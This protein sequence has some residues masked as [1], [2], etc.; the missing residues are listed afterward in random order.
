MN[1]EDEEEEEEMELSLLLLLL[2]YALEKKK[3]SFRKMLTRQQRRNRKGVFRREAL[4]TPEVAPFWQIYNSGQMLALITRCGFN[5]PF[6]NELLLLFTPYF[7]SCTPYGDGSCIVKKQRPKGGR[8]R[9]VSA[10]SCLALV[11]AWTR[12]RGSNMILQIV[13]GLT[14]SPL[15]LWLR[16]GRR[17]CVKVLNNNDL[18]AVKM[19]TDAKLEEFSV[20]V[21]E[22]Y[23]LLKKTWGATDGLKIRLQSPTDEIKQS[24]FYNGWT[25][26]HYTTNL[27]LFSPDGKIRAMY[28]NAPGCLHDS[29]LANWSGIYDKIEK[30][31]SKQGYS[32]VVDSA[33]NK[34]DRGGLIKSHQT[35][36][37]SDGARRQPFAL[38]DQA[39]S[40]RQLS[41]WGM[42]GLQASFPRLK[43]RLTYEEV[44]ERKIIMALIVLLYNFRA[45]TVGQNQIASTFMPWLERDANQYSR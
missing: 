6:F 24:L 43:D 31:H 18:A 45:S 8:K 13:F 14:S 26:D 39:T 1:V 28:V 5:H 36:V 44:G 2:R 21:E 22:K 25:H 12:T 3:R 16:F 42:R 7:D 30:L 11:L 40:L 23:P 29:T 15:D 32:V 19:P 27:F 10:V 34:E 20:I 37:G 35:N 4:Q 33:F 38:N 9:T 17:I 41:E